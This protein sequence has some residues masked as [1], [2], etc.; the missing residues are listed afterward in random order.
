MVAPIRYE[1]GADYSAELWEDF[2]EWI[3]DRCGEGRLILAANSKYDCEYI[4]C[5]TGIE[6]LHLPSLC[7]YTGIKYLPTQDKFL[8]FA[9]G[10]VEDTE[11]R[12]L[13][14]RKYDVLPAGH[15][16]QAIGAFK[17][18]IH[19]P[20]NV[21]VMSICEQYTANIPLFFPSIKFL[22]ELYEQGIDVLKQMSIVSTDSKK[23]G[24]LVSFR[25]RYDPND[26]KDIVSV[27]HWLLSADYYDKDWMPHIQYFSSIE[28]LEYLLHT[29]NL[30]EISE[31]MRI[32]NKWR[33]QEVY[34]RWANVVEKVRQFYA[35]S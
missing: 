25:G 22:M 19:F 4:K 9:P 32:T 23:P 17:G 29:V 15:P 30:A 16:W 7:E 27:R 6:P 8:Y 28:H 20:Y 24:S 34:H 14:V 5:F 1:L 2:N 10:E 35:G 33:R 3:I 31:K 11:L 13:M 12:K 26:Y 18:I 21:S